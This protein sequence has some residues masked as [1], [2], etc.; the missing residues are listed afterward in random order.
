MKKK[1][2]DFNVETFHLFFWSLL[3]LGQSLISLPKV[4]HILNKKVTQLVL[5]LD[6]ST[7]AQKSVKKTNQNKHS[8]RS[9]SN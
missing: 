6:E 5:G 8:V 1:S 4:S 9:C 3:R 7:N 2:F